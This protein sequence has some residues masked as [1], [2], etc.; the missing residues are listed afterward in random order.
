[1]MPSSVAAACSSKLKPWQNFLR[2]A[3]PHA[4]LTRLPN[5]ACST[6]CMPPDSSKKRSSDDRVLRRH[7]AEARFAF[8]EIRRDLLGRGAR[9]LVVLASSHSIAGSSSSV[10]AR[11]LRARAAAHRRRAQPR[12]RRAHFVAARGRFAQPERHR[13]RLA[14]RVGDA[15]RRRCRRAGCAT[16][17]CRAGTRRPAATRWR[18]PRSACR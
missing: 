13:G 7:D 14:L 8:A 9:Q 6:S 2:S 11:R 18:S 12:N 3:R 15:H 4:R 17:C 16:T 1:M 5:G 10:L